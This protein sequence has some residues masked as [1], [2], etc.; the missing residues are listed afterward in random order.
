MIS[1]LI[2]HFNRPKELKVCLEAF[3][4]LNIDNVRY[5]VSDDGSDIPI[6][7]NFKNLKIDTFIISERNKGLT[8]NINQGIKKCSTKYILYCQEDFVP[9]KALK[10]FL[11]EILEILVTG[12]ADMVRL[13]ANYTFPKL[14]TLSGN[15]KLIPKFSWRNFY[16]NTFQYSD[17][18]FITTKDFFDTY[19]Y[20]LDNT[21]GAYGENEYAIRIMKSKAKIAIVNQHLFEDNNNAISVIE[22]NQLRKKRRTLKRLGLHKLIR[23]I[24][25]HLEYLFYNPRKRGLITI[26]NKRQH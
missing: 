2:T 20:Y 13:K 6:Q 4:D 17:H 8:S 10:D 18:P 25:L 14:H 5:V 3:Q 23:A 26:K 16:Y 21:S 11:P 15:I 12:K 9:K 7:D 24:R 1:V 22:N 19:G